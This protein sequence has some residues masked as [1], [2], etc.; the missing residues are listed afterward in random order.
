MPDDNKHMLAFDPIS[1]FADTCLDL[2]EISRYFGSLDNP[3]VEAQKQYMDAVDGLMNQ[4]RGI[5]TTVL[6]AVTGPVLSK[7]DED[8]RK[9]HFEDSTRRDERT[10]DNALDEAKRI[11]EELG[12]VVEID[13]DTGRPVC[14]NPDHDHTHDDE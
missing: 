9:S 10:P 5:I 14:K 11:V 4:M 8:V 7:I 2:A 6:T 13:P 1:A 12:M 3:S